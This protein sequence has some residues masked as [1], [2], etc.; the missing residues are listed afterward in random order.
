MNLVAPNRFAV[1]AIQQLAGFTSPV[2]PHS[3]GPP[4]GDTLGAETSLA[5]NV[6][7]IRS[8]LRKAAEVAEESGSKPSG[9]MP[10]RQ[11]MLA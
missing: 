2:E 7:R 3:A 10:P 6:K 4:P 1:V 9:R 5:I 8:H 11:K